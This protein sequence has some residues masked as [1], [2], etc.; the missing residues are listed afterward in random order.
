MVLDRAAYVVAWS[1]VV[2]A[3]ALLFWTR[4]DDIM[5]V[6]V[7]VAAFALFLFVVT[8]LNRDVRAAMGRMNK[9]HGDGSLIPAR[10]FP[11]NHLRWGVFGSAGGG[12]GLGLLRILLFLEFWMV[13]WVRGE[14]FNALAAIAGFAIAIMLTLRQMRTSI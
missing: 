5:I 11:L 10:G 13:L 4:T 2:L 3:P 7:M 6:A 1:V 14:S 9:E 8:L 12:V